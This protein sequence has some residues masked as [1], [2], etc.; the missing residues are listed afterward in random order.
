MNLGHSYKRRFF[1]RV[2]KHGPVP[3]HVS[4]LGRCWVWTGY[5]D[6]LGYGRVANGSG[7]VERA[8]R[9][10]WIL[11]HGALPKKCVLHRCDNRACVRP[12]HLFEGTRADNNRDMHSKGRSA[13]GQRVPSG[14]RH[15]ARR[16]PGNVKRGALHPGAKLTQ[17]DVD[18][19]R[20]RSPTETFRS[21][22][23]EFGVSL[24]LISLIVRRR[25]WK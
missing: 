6:R 21:L 10:S 7:A 20:A 18:S 25:L 14:D 12:S 17:A 3:L 4:K 13:H 24:S 1:A 23:N 22:A 2:D 15:W 5:R 16:F 9:M 19:I 8:H 11:T